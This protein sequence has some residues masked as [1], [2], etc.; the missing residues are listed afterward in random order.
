MALASLAALLGIFAAARFS[1][2]AR[3]PPILA[4]GWYLDRFYQ[5]VLVDRVAL[6]S[7]SA[8]SRFDSRIVD[9]GVNS[10]AL[11]TRL[12]GRFLSL[13]DIHVVDGG[14]RFT[15][16]AVR[17]SGIPVRLLQTGSVQTYALF[18]LAGL[19][20]VLGVYIAR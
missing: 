19:L 5:S 15:A 9:G 17:L 2:P 1:L 8:L 14:V 18:V 12:S 20:V 11:L 4:H 16:L 10:T 13:W 3:M 6:G 7:G